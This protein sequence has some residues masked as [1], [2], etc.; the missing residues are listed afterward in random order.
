[1]NKYGRIPVRTDVD[2]KYGGLLKKFKLLMTDIEL[3]QK[4]AELHKE[5][6][7]LF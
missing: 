2:S 5:L 1:M 6:R 7:R 4:S 3:G